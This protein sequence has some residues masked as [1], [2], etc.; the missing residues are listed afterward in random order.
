VIPSLAR[1]LSGSPEATPLARRPRI[2]AVSRK[3]TAIN[4]L[5]GLD[6]GTVAA[7]IGGPIG[8]AMIH[9]DLPGRTSRREQQASNSLEQEDANN[10]SSH[11]P[12]GPG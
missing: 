9:A 1:R 12:H 7:D 2:C 4:S 8:T 5:S 11:R 3:F 10:L 6:P